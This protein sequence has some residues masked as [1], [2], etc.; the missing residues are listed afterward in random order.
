MAPLFI[1][2]AHQVKFES[3]LAIP[4]NE[5]MLNMFRALEASGLRG[6]LGCQS[7]LYELELE[8]F[9]DTALVKD[10]DI[11]GAVSGK[12]FSISQSR[13]AEVFELPTERLVDF[14]EVPK[15]LVYDARSIFSKSGEPVSTYGKNKLMKYEYR[16]LND[17]LDK[18]IT[19]KAGS[20]DAVTNERFLMMTAIQFGLK[21][22]WSKRLFSVLKEMVDKTQNKAKGYAA[23][24]CVLLKSNPTITMG[25]SVPFPTSKVLSIKT[26]HTYIAMNQTIDARGQSDEPGMAPVAIVKRKS[27]SKKES[28]ST[29]VPKKRRTVKIKASPSKS[30]LDM[31]I[32]AQVAVPLTII[33]PTPAATAE[34][35]PLPKR[36][37]KKRKLVLPRGSDDETVEERVT[38][39]T[40]EDVEQ[41]VTVEVADEEPVVEHT[42]EVDVIIGQVLVET[43][44]MGTD[45]AD[46]LNKLLMK[47]MLR[48]CFFVEQQ[49]TVEVADEEPVVEHTDE[50]DVII[51]QVLV[52]T[53]QMGTDE[54]EQF[55]QTFDE[56]NVEEMFFEDT[57]VD[58]SDNFEQWLDESYEDFVAT[59]TVDK[60]EGSKDIVGA[61]APEKAVGRN[62]T[63]E[64]L[65]SIDDLLM[66]ISDNMMLPSLTAAEV[67]KI[68][69]GSSIELNEVQDRDW[70]YA[71]LPWISTHDKGKEP[72]EEVDI[73]KGN[74][75]REMVELIC[76]DVEFLVQL[77][78]QV[79]IDVVEFFHSF[80]LNKLSDL[81]SL[82]DLKEKEKLML[83]WAEADSLEMAVRRRVY[84]LAKYREMLLRKFLDSH[85][86]YYTPGQPWTATA[87]QIIDFLSVAH[88]KSL[89]DLLEQQKE[90]GL[91]MERA[92]SSTLLDDSNDGGG[93]VLTQFFSLANASDVQQSSNSIP[94]IDLVSSDGSTVYRSPS[95]QF[96]AFQEADSSGPNV[97]LALGPSISVVA[98]EEQLYFVQRPE[99]PPR[100]SQRQ[101]PSTSSTDSSMRFKSDDFS[102]D[103]TA[104][105]QSSLPATS[106]APSAS[107]YALHTFISQRLD[108]QLQGIRQISESQND[109]LSKLNTLEKGLRDTLWQQ[110]EAF[111]T[112]IHSAR[113]DGRTIDDVQT[114]RFNEFRKGVLAHSASVTADLMDFRKEVKEINIKVTSLDE[115]VAGIRNDLLDFS[116]KA[117]ETLNIITDQLSELVAYINR[118]GDNKKGEVSSRGP[119]PPP[120]DQGRPGGSSGNRGTHGSSGGSRSR[121]YIGGHSK[122]R[123]SSSSG[124]PFRRSFEDWLG[125][126]CC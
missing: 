60:D 31:V 18:A 55:E 84:I 30:S 43:S 126:N 54:A 58:K 108:N 26:V 46:S 83:S 62:Q 103:D 6:F 86:K 89:E 124:G 74:P 85:R 19:V 65:M 59:D 81:E 91:V 16:L 112:L 40:I 106:T 7:V 73:V 36:K 13:F 4:D 5:G 61:K 92:S 116:A 29:V 15:N 23:Q 114:L 11:T 17:I 48:K 102:M 104:A 95:P 75:A 52:E 67:T 78:D 25:E 105:N 123:Y 63:D 39:A 115:Q 101:D 51:G 32:V 96:D 69:L 3:V 94:D 49:V 76:G 79:M 110:E 37:S 72:L 113:Q 28:E 93:A 98:Q 9:F 12:F 118:C 111:R 41:Q 20:F 44:Q 125:Y 38:V 117:Q 33:E 57:S 8:Q 90:H 34:K 109:V 82:R 121:G 53:S 42:D 122:K 56:T 2:N 50:V 21:V 14:S 22:N 24:I 47:Q 70:Y 120:D 99:S 80:S 88:S 27:K 35:S 10:G 77:R 119:H 1:A 68:R 87:S 107:L 97:Q 45:E 64:E 71:S 66:K 100:T